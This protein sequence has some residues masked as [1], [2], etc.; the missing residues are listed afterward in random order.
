[1]RSSCYV[2]IIR[3]SRQ[4]KVEIAFPSCLG[5][6]QPVRVDFDDLS[7]PIRFSLAPLPTLEFGPRLKVTW[8]PNIAYI[9]PG[10]ARRFVR[11]LLLLF[12]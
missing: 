12:A 7:A 8:R 6:G 9:L 3:E 4:L 2:V 10:C 11:I 5:H 1:M